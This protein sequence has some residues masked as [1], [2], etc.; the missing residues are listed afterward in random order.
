[1][2]NVIELQSKYENVLVSTTPTQ[3]A[4]Y[5]QSMT[6]TMNGTGAKKRKEES[7]EDSESEAPKGSL[8][9]KNDH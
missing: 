4:I 6:E 2:L 9:I 7:E 5:F 3:L 8:R 1:M